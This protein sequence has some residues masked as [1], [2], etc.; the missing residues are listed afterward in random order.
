MVFL[1][2]VVIF[3]SIYFQWQMAVAALVAL[4][5]DILITAGIYALVGFEVTRRP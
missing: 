5:H 4:A 1:A 3:L 2:A